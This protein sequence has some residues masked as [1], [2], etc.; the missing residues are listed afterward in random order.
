MRFAIVAI[1]RRNV[2]ELYHIFCEP[3]KLD[4]IAVPEERCDKR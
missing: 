1:N 2:K 4:T 3:L